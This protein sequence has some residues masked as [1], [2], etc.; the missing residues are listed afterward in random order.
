MKKSTIISV[1][2]INA[3]IYERRKENSGKNKR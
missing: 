3:T 2:K 1:E